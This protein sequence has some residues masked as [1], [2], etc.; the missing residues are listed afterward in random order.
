MRPLGMESPDR[1]VDPKTLFEEGW[2]TG[3]HWKE[4]NYNDSFH[5]RAKGDPD[6]LYLERRAYFEDWFMSTFLDLMPH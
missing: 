4:K 3:L 6:I 1:H 5:Y 2:G